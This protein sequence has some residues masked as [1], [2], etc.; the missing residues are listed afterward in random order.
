MPP[1]P[2]GLGN[3]RESKGHRGASSG[4]R[5][6]NCCH[7]DA[8]HS[9]GMERA[10]RARCSPALVLHRPQSSIPPRLGTCQPTLSVGFWG[11]HVAISFLTCF[12]PGS[13]FSCF[14]TNGCSKYSFACCKQNI[15]PGNMRLVLLQVL[16]LRLRAAGGTVLLLF[17]LWVSFE[18]ANVLVDC[19][20]PDAHCCSRGR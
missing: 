18:V 2:P 7:A 16:L 14:F 8:L 20:V 13:G 5:I 6:S 3:Q 11:I 17:C 4:K 9:R 15:A 1:G 19:G 10:L 12:N